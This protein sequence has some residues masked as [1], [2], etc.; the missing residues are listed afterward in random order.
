MNTLQVDGGS[1]PLAGTLWWLLAGGMLMSG[2]AMVGSFALVLP[3]RWLER[4][5]LPL[6]AVAAGTLLG[7]AL[8]HMLPTGYATVAPACSGWW[9]A[10]GFT[11]FLAMEQFLRWHHSHHEQPDRVAAV[12]WLILV[13]DALHN[14][15]GGLGV[16]GTFLVD[17]RAGIVAW[18]AAAAHEVPQE[19]GDFGVLVHGG[20]PARSA[21]AWN[22]LSALTFPAGALVAY[23]VSQRVDVGGLALFGAGNFIYI[24]ASDL[25]PEIKASGNLSAAALHFVLFVAG[26]L[27]VAAAAWAGA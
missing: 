22:F 20:W 6:V 13:G 7:G 17:P 24:A 9:T 3:P 16:A 12:G 27:L 4:L 14:F 5:V 21:L 10:G 15:L 25:I 18:C 19:L 11:T 23:A 26:V 8:F 2:I 1:L